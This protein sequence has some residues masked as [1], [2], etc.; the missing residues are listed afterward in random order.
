M[1]AKGRPRLSPEE[2]EL[3][4]AEYCRRYKAARAETGLPVFPTGK[5]ETRQH[6]EWIALYKTHDRLGRRTRGQCERCSEPAAAGSIFCET[7]RAANAG[8]GGP[9]PD[10]RRRLLAR[11]N[12]R[13]PVCDLALEADAVGFG[14]QE[15]GS[16]ARALLHPSCARL[17]T[18]ALAVGPEGLTR[19]RELLWPGP[20]P[21]AKKQ[22]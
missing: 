3:R 2:L 18:S 7:H 1:P 14:R 12:H 11:Q 4:I 19:L 20:V 8:D 15:A 9:A 16:E 17:A 5:R 6:R 10:E 22:R 13:C 21:R